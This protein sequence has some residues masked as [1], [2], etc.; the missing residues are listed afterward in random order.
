MSAL[1]RYRR[2]EEYYLPHH[3]S[4]TYVSKATADAAIAE[5]QAELAALKAQRCETCRF[6]TFVVEQAFGCANPN[7]GGWH[8]ADF[9]CSFWQPREEAHRERN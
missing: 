1:D 3:G 6:W 9:V 2:T 4:H 7:V 5:L 8:K